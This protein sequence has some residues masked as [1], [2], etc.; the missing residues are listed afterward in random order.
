MPSEMVK[1]VPELTFLIALLLG[2]MIFFSVTNPSDSQP[3]VLM[4]GFALILGILYSALRLISRLFNLAERMRPGQHKGLLFTGTVLPV[5]LL[6]LQSLGQL[7]VRDV[8]T[9]VVL[10]VVAHFYVSRLSNR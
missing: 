5:L 8:V 9:L 2:G 7:T 6:A 3:A 1:R 4:A 10:F